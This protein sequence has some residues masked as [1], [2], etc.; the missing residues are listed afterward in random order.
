MHTSLNPGNRNKQSV[1]DWWHSVVDSFSFHYSIYRC[2]SPFFRVR[3][4]RRYV[5][6]LL[7]GLCCCCFFFWRVSDVSRSDCSTYVHI[8]QLLSTPFNNINTQNIWE[9]SLS[10]R[11]VCQSAQCLTIITHKPEHYFIL[12]CR[13]FCTLFSNSSCAFL[14]LIAIH[15][16][17]SY[18]LMILRYNRWHTIE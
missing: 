12:Q 16:S 4:F 10:G 13:A 7:F 18:H 9:T 17:N 14:Y 5:L 2:V 1:K 3:S 8:R 11:W 15:S 6:L